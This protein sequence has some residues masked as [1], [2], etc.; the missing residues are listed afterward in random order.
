MN[1]VLL[2]KFDEERGYIPIKI[3]PSQLRK[4]SNEDVFKEIA[5]NAIGFGTQV[6]YQA[7]TLADVHCLAKRFSIPRSEA[8]GGSELYALVLISREGEE[9][10]D[11]KVLGESI[12]Q[13]KSDWEARSS[14]MEYLY[15]SINPQ[16]E[17]ALPFVAASQVSSGGSRPLLPKEL[18]IQKEGFFAEGHTITRNL[19]MGLSFV[20]LFWILYS[21]YNLFSFSFMFILGV[22][23]FSIIAKKDITLK[24]VE[25]FIFF[26]IILLFI[27]LFFE[28]IGDPSGIS[29]LGSF[30]DFSHPD[31]AILSF[32]SGILICFGLDRGIGIDKASFII[33][34]IG[35]IFLLLFFFT[36]IFDM[37]FQFF[38]GT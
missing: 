3:V 14:L 25:G 21:N 23:S 38:Q 8:R 32:F 2:C 12:E 28:F 9:K 16:K 24:V 17:P 27:K 5:R 37:L 1:G 35:V 31:L 36:P 33:G 20:A 4:H 13:M 10:F 26:F 6:D 19:L 18:F 15:H 7:F 29:F 30:P 34:I 22:F 11:K